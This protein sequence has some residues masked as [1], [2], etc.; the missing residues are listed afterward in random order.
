MKEEL[1]ENKRKVYKQGTQLAGI[2]FL[3]AFMGYFFDIIL[4]L[5]GNVEY[6]SVVT[7][8]IGTTL[9]FLG[10]YRMAKGKGYHGMFALLGILSLIGLIILFLMPNRYEKNTADS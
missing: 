5:G 8:F 1:I 9:F 3:I 2:G 10:C 7:Y 6:V 4:K